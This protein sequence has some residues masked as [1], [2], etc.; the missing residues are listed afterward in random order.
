MS[1]LNDSQIQE[2]YEEQLTKAQGKL[3]TVNWLDL[4]EGRPARLTIF[5][6]VLYSRNDLFD[7][8]LIKVYGKDAVRSVMLRFKVQG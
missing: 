3:T 8:A 6:K 4:G 7:R 5:R 1:G 2:R